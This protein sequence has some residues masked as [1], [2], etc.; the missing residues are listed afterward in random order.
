MPATAVPAAGL[1]VFGA[2]V[3]PARRHADPGRDPDEGEGDEHDDRDADRPA[4]RRQ[5]TSSDPQAMDML[6]FL[7][8]GGRRRHRGRDVV[9]VVGGDRA[10]ARRGVDAR[11]GRDQ[12]HGDDRPCRR[13]PVDGQPGRD[14]ADGRGGGQRQQ[15]RRAP[16]GRPR[17]TAP[18]RAGGPAPAPKIA[19]VATWVVDSAK[20]R[21]DEARMTVAAL[22]SAAK[23][24]GVWISLTRLPSVWMIRQPPSVGA[25]RDREPGGEDHPE[26]RARSRRASTPAVISVRVMMPIVFWASLV[27]WASATIDADTIWP[28]LEALLDGAVVGRAW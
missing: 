15:P 19:P 10:A 25:Q 27:P 1:S 9:D 7:S 2:V 3:G 11:C 6:P 8:G 14:G 26:R 4:R 5:T 20:P 17:P 23:P 16:S 22:V 28:S 21:C 13:V 24:C 18:R 12:D